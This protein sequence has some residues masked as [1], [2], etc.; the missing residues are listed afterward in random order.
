MSTYLM[1]L[2]VHE[3][4]IRST[5]EPSPIVSEEIMPLLM[6][7]IPSKLG[8]PWSISFPDMTES[9]GPVIYR[10]KLSGVGATDL[11]VVVRRIRLV[12][13][14]PEQLRPTFPSVATQKLSSC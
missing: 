3:W 13:K 9:T 2:A 12:R 1:E 10:F 11:D 4:D 5:R 14:L 8:R 7:R 6:D